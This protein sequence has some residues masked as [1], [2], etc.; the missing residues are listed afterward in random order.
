MENLKIAL[1]QMTSTDDVEKN[2]DQAF[3][4]FGQVKAK[5]DLLSL[6]ENCLF[7]RVDDKDRMPGFDLKDKIFDRFSEYAM[8]QKVFIHLGSVPLKKNGKLY[9]SSV[10]IND[11][12]DISAEYSKIHLFDVDVEG[13]RPSRESSVF[14]HGEHPHIWDVKG[15][16]VGLSICYDL[17]FPELF[18]YYSKHPVDLILLPAA[19]LVP[20]G[21]AHWDILLRARAIEAQSYVAAAAQCGKHVGVKGGERQTFGHSMIIDPWGT[22]VVEAFDE[23]GI[24]E[25]TLE[26]SRIEKV[27]GQIP[28]KNHRRL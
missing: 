4:L 23:I 8:N 27:R 25:A 7:L 13:A 20:T 28:M 22:K 5:V 12:G 16:K 19:F 9:S 1:C 6:P 21:K 18:L 24:I 3:K 17:R 2:I 26:K 15:W 14:S 11:D 10:V